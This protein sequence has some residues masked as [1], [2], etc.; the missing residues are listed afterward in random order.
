MRDG[1]NKINE[2]LTSFKKKYYLN[3]FLRG[4]LLTLTLVLFYFLL[5]ALLEYNL[6]LSGWVRFSIFLTFFLVVIFSVY[7]FLKEPLRWWLYRKGLG[8]EETATMVGRLFPEIRDRLLNLIQLSLNQ[9]PTALLE[10][11]ITQKSRQFEHLTFENAIDL[12]ENKRYLKYLLVPMAFILL[13]VVVNRGVFTQSTLRIVQ[14]NREFSPQA[15]FKF[16]IQNKNLNAFFNEDFTLN[17]RLVGEALPE[18]VYLVSPAQRIKLEMTK[19]GEFAY[20]FEKIQNEVPF[21]LEASGFYS[22]PYTIRLVNRPELTRIKMRLQFPRYLGKKEEELINT[23]NIEIPEGTKITWQISTANT[24]KAS[25]GFSSETG[26]NPMQIIDNQLFTFGKGFRN[27]DGYWIDLENENSKNKDKINYS[28]LVIKDQYPQI[29]VDHLKDSVLFKTIFLGGTISDDYGLTELSLNYQIIKD[30]NTRNKKTTISINRNSPQQSFFYQWH[31]D[32]LGLQPGDKLN[33]YLQVWDNDGVNGRKSTQ[34]KAFVFALP[35]EEELKANIAKTQSAAESKIDESLTKAKDIREALDE[36]QQKLK[37]KQTLDWQDKKM[38]EDLVQQKNSLDQMINELQ[39]QNELLEQKKDAFSE[40]NEKIREK[41]A[42]IQKLMDELLDP[43]TKKLF[44]ELEKLLKENSDMNQIQKMLDKMNRKEINLEK[45]LERTLELFKQLKYDYKLD[46]AV[47]E[48][49]EQR[50]K[51]EKLLEKTQE[52][53]GEKKNERDGKEG[54]KG[55]EDKQ[56]DNQENKS[57]DKEGSDQEKDGSTQDQKP[58]NQKLADDQ[59]NLEKDFEQFQKTLEDLDKMGEELNQDTPTPSKED[60]DQVKD[61]QQQS[62]ESLKQGNPKKSVGPQKKSISQMRQMQQQLEDAQS[63]MEM[64][65][66]MENLEALRQIIHGLI[67]LSFDQE[68]LM[69]DFGQVQ[70]TDPRYIQLSQNQLKIKDDSK[71]LE[72]SLLSLAKRDA[73]MGSII[74]KEVGELNSH[75]DKVADHIKERR[76]SNAGTEMQLSMTSINNLAVMLDDHY[77]MMMDMMANAM[78]A[79]GKKKGKQQQ[80]TLGQLQQQLNQKIEQLKNG[81][82]SGRQ[83]SEEL[84]KMAAEQERIRRALQEMQD[85]LK[86]EGGKTLGN[87]LP[88]KMEQTEMDLVNKQ[89]TEQTIRRQKEIEVRLLEAEKSMREQNLDQERK[90]E[91]AKDYDKEIPRAFEEYLRLK[92]KEVELLKTVPPKLYPYYKKEVNEYFKRIGNHN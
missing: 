3:L 56:K 86:N 85:K 46:Q 27:P 12:R 33:Y 20:T 72:D 13:I 58:D 51:Q 32:S 49:K 73:F 78:P 60:L 7:K 79:K 87:D 24:A 10:A 65:I 8:Q 50:E 75:L 42:Q 67:K 44:E 69:K 62:K 64:D 5:A 52:L 91:T 77:D 71:V 43:E 88:G 83:Y 82:K 80:P 22:D 11:G 81:G 92:E 16:I 14:F 41:A 31:I 19:P 37:G 34:S 29:E 57:G 40:Q 89:I 26:T 28:I 4:V 30:G 55:A 74:T 21:Q 90:G 84:A 38:L 18:A 48:I 63:S 66:D 45:E 53:T 54:E 36:A 6:W 2:K 1:L 17:L 9:K 47:N 39:K 25:I 76:K 35:G 59:E 61:S 23:G 15:P 68:A 70:Q